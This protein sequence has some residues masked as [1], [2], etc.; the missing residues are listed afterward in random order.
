MKMRWE[1]EEE[2]YEEEEKKSSNGNVVKSEFKNRAEVEAKFN[3]MALSK[4][5]YD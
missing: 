3:E 4:E 5:P 1:K 2:R